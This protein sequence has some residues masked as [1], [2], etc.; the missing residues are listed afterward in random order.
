MKT[1]QLEKLC[2]SCQK[3]IPRHISR[4]GRREVCG[5]PECT[6]QKNLALA[7][8]HDHK[9]REKQREEEAKQGK[10]FI[11]CAVCGAEFELIQHTHL[12]RHQM[13][14]DDYKLL[15]PDHPMMSNAMLKKRA[16]GSINQSRYLTY[17]GKPIDENFHNFMVGV[18]LGD[19]SL[20][21]RPKKKNARYAEGGNNQAYLAWKYD[22]LRQYLPCTFAEKLSAP[23]VKSGKRYLGWWIKTGVHPDLTEIHKLF[24]PDGKKVLNPM[25]LSRYF[26]ELSLAVWV[27][28]DGHVAADGSQSFL[29]THS[30]RKSEV[31]WL[32]SLLQIDFKLKNTIIFNQKKQPFIRFPRHSTTRLKEIISQFQ[33]P[34]MEYKYQ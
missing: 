29:Y 23:H 19:G 31:E 17:N 8:F 28:D 14:I 7:R 27:C 33:I 34:G 5:N 18:M 30:F 32:S 1:Q 2:V 6:R 20:E 24:Y 10:E 11:S 16:L 3:P 15:Y 25:Y 21:K 22:F 12:R 4:Y 13:T 26:N 9:R